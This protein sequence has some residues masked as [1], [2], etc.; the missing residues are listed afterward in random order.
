MNQ[1]ADAFSHFGENYQ[2]LCRTGEIKQDI[3]EIAMQLHQENPQN[4]FT[5]VSFVFSIRLNINAAVTEKKAQNWEEM[6]IK[7]PKFH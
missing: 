5:R 6:A 1:N 2:N 4:L 3:L 7:L